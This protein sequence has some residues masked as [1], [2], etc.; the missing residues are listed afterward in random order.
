VPNVIAASS[1]T[2]GTTLRYDAVARQY[3]LT[4]KTDKAWAGSCKTFTLTLADGTQHQAN[5]SFI[6]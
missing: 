4:V 1:D 5:F 3:I 6:K 2:S